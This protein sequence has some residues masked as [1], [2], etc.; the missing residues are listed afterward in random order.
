M[1]ID[2]FLK[3]FSN[4]HF[5]GIGGISLSALAKLM[6]AFGKNVTGSDLTKSHITKELEDLGIKVFY[7]HKKKNIGQSDLVV[8]SGAIKE[9]N[10]ELVEANKKNLLVLERSEFLGLV[11]KQYKKIIAIAGTH[12]KTTTVGMLASIFKTAKLNPTVHIGGESEITNGN[13]LIGSRKF[14]ITEACEY[15][16]SYLTLDQNVGVILNIENDHTDHFKTP[17]DIYK[18]FSKFYNNSKDVCIIYEPHLS[19]INEKHQNVI[20]FN[21]NNDTNYFAKNIELTKQKTYRFDVYYK[22][23]KLNTFEIKSALKH[24]VYNALAAIAV[25]RHYKISIKNIK[26][27]LLNFKGIKR[28]LETVGKV[29]EANVIH[30]YAHHPTEIKETIKSVKK[31]YNKKVVCVFQPHT[32]TRT[33]SLMVSFLKSFIKCEH[34]LIYKT[35]AA[36]EKKLKE[37]SAKTLAENLSF[38]KPNTKYFVSFKQIKKH[39]K[40]ISNKD[41]VILILGAGNIEDFAYNYF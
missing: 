20:T 25:S 37:G 18:S 5:I 14:F 23:K 3:N 1:K 11:A 21:L 34:V 36:R 32:Y 35:Y 22:G 31:L 33:K 13:M 29:N 10:P 12:G 15:K 24:N 28:R 2:N 16:D 39:L 27:G 19:F 38:I 7:K 40:K 9:N 6:L 4:I 30:D 17:K 8:F 26:E 41:H